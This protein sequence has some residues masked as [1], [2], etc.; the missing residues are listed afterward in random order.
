MKD[1][2][3]HT[4]PK[5]KASRAYRQIAA[6]IIGLDYKEKPSVLARLFNW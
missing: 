2:L 3:I 6:K 1:A 4:H 5:S